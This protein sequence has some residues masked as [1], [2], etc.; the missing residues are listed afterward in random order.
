MTGSAWR[1][2]AFALKTFAAAMLAFGI[3]LWIDLPRP[4][5]AVGT[6][7]ITS[8]ALAGATRSK[9]VYRVGGTLVGAAVAVVLVPNLVDAPEL[10]SLAIALWVG[11]CLYFALLDRTPG[12]YLPMLAGYTAA[13]VGFPSVSEPGAIFDTAVSR[14]EEITLGILCASLVSTVV[15]PQSVRPVIATRLDGW[16]REARA[17][18]AEGLGRFRGRRDGR[19]VARLRLAADAVALDALATPLRYERPGDARPVAAMAVLRQH[20]L[21][22]LPIVGGVADRVGVLE[23]AGALPRPV[24]D[25]LDRVAEWLAAGTTDPAAAE[26]LRGEVQALDAGLGPRPDWNAL[27]LASLLGRLR[28]FIDLSQDIRVLRAHLTAGVPPSGPLRFRYTAKSRRIRHADHGMALLS[29]VGTV[30]AILL[31]CAIWIAT[32][33]SDGSAAPMMA[34][35]TCCMFAALDDPAP[36]ILGFANSALLGAAASGLYLFA[37]LPQATTFEMVVLALAPAL[38]P[39]GYFMTRPRT[40]P[41]ALGA[42]V[43]GSTM[44]ALQNGYR[45]D[46]ESF[47]N[48]TLAIVIGMWTAAA[49][50]RLMRSVGAAWSARR[51]HRTNRRS[52]AEAASRLGGQDGLRLAALMLDRVGLIAPRL[53]ALPPE[54]AAWTAGLLGEVRAGINVVELRRAR[55]ALPEEARTRVERLLAALA[56]HFR[57]DAPHAPPAILALLDDSLDVAG[58]VPRHPEAERTLL[59]LVGLRRGLFP[60]A[61]AYRPAGAGTLGGLAA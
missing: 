40:A 1:D 49:V 44:L 9:A 28:D 12:S 32:G 10:L 35:V 47:A 53:A 51:L 36:Q 45:G 57:T 55:R 13:L 23:A 20:M 18:A 33:W 56:G 43:N 2:W 17:W 16:S 3:A 59:A 4:Y 50:I 11:A 39:C 27:V 31:T 52:L 24:R 61:P 29:S 42:A 48:S 21:M 38:I 54:D 25:L 60:D 34:A 7:Y 26:R 37:I 14:A 41:L 22:V 8:Q 30:V 19:R 5:W 46:F 15:L 58:R 6:V